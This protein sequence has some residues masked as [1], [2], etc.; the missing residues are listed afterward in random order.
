M[1]IVELESGQFTLDEVIA[2]A[3]NEAIVLRKPDGDM[4]ALVPVD[5]FDV[6]VELLKKNAEFM[7]FLKELSQE[8]TTISLKSL[9]AELGL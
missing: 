2:L 7:L 1:R 5:D 6:K 8:K 3:K 9:R 4:F